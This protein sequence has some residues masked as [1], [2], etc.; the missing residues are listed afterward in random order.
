M[1][2]GNEKKRVKVVFCNEVEPGS[3]LVDYDSPSPLRQESPFRALNSL[4]ENNQKVLNIQNLKHANSLNKSNHSLTSPKHDR[5]DRK[6]EELYSPS[7]I[8][9]PIKRRIESP[10]KHRNNSAV[11]SNFKYI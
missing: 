8:K 10:K 11:I 6:K 2:R 1:N 5:N 4:Y 3:A 7:K 9:S